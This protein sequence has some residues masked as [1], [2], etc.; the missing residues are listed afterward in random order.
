VNTFIDVG[1]CTA[2]ARSLDDFWPSAIEALEE[3]PK[4]VPFA[5][6]YTIEDSNHP[7]SISSTCSDISLQTNKIAVL[8]AAL[9]IPHSHDAAPLRLK[10]VDSEE[11]CAPFFR[12]AL[13]SQDL[14]VLHLEDGSLPAH[15][16]ANISSPSFGEV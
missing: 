15:L 10:L 1:S 2:T 14:T 13:N 5:L 16:V 12:K 7:S 4:D 8:S 3:N 6:I 11:G 9:G